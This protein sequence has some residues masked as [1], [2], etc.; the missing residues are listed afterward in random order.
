VYPDPGDQGSEEPVL[1][2]RQWTDRNDGSQ[3]FLA[4]LRPGFGSRTEAPVGVIDLPIDGRH[5][6]PRYEAEVNVP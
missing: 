6:W 3:G 4:A 1:L 5:D 2:W